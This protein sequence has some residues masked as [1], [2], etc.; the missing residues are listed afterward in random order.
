MEIK[1]I[2]EKDNPLLSRTE[3][4]FECLY[5]GE[6]TPTILEVKKKLVALLNSDN[7]LL[8]I[9]TL[10]PYFGEG[11][12][13]GY[14]KVYQDKKALDEIEPKHIIEKNSEEKAE[15]EGEE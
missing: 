15:T 7:D 14:A 4:T 11:K 3:I 9:D 1:I 5:H 8:V 12:A 10:K 6:P 2:E 13:K